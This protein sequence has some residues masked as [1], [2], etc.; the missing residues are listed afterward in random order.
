MSWFKKSGI[1]ESTNE[2]ALPEVLV[3]SLNAFPIHSLIIG[4]KNQIIFKSHAFE[5]L[6]ILKENKLVNEQILSIVRSAR[7]GSESVT[8]DFAIKRSGIGDLHHRQSLERRLRVDGAREN[9]RGSRY[10]TGD[11]RGDTRR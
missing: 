1:P 4:A 2:P 7:K 8:A 6:N 11:F 3:K 5:T 10:V 9:L